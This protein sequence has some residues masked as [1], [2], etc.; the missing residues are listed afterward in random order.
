MRLQG[1]LGARLSGT[2][3]ALTPDPAVL[4]R[5][6]VPGVYYDPTWSMWKANWA[7]V[8]ANYPA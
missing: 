2:R 1:M 7:T 4:Q 6:H 8:S 3:L 5:G